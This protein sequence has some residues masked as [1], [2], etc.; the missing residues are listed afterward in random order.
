MQNKEKMSLE[1]LKDGAVI[2]AVDA[3]LQRVLDNVIDPNSDPL[4]KRTITLTISVKPNQERTQIGITA[5]AKSSLAPDIAINAIA[6]VGKEAG[7]GVA[8]EI[9]P[10]Q[11]EFP[12]DG[13]VTDFNSARQQ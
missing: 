8:N 11:M 5:Q 6:L 7:A 3:E 4:A 2:E 10:R 9:Q 13:K 1:N 12:E